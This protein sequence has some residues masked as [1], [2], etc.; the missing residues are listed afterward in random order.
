MSK[1]SETTY[2]YRFTLLFKQTVEGGYIVACPAFPDLVIEGDTLAEA[3][4]RAE[5]AIRGCV[6]RLRKNGIAIPCDKLI[7][8]ELVE[9]QICIA[10]SPG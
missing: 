6:Q 3:Q 9:K 1:N 10:V 4:A 8:R 2:E 7:A 5:D